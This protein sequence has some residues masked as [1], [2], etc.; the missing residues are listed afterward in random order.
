MATVRVRDRDLRRRRRRVGGRRDGRGECSRAGGIRRRIAILGRHRS[1]MIAAMSSPLHVVRAG[2]GP[3]SC[4]STAAPPTTRRGRS[5]SRRTSARA[6]HADRLRSPHDAAT[7]EDAGRR[8]ARS[9]T[10]DSRRCSSSARASAPSSRSS[11]CAR[12]PSCVRRGADR[13]ADG[14]VR[15]PRSGAERRSSPSSIAAPP[16]RVGRPQASSSYARVLGD[17]AFERMPRAFQE[18]STAKWAEIR[19]DSRRL[20]AYRPRY[21]EL[22]A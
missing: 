19:A 11:W 5:S 21:A 13:A 1:P 2:R 15:R 20:I 14:A 3:G 8:R 6:V 9:S 18:R 16:S 22:A 17:A 7:V 12:D 10:S 4:S